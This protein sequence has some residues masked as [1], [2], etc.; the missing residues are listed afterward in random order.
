MRPRHRLVTLAL[1][2]ARG[3]AAGAPGPRGN[4]PTVTRRTGVML[5]AR[6]GINLRRLP[7]GTVVLLLV[8][9]FAAPAQAWSARTTQM[10]VASNGT[11]ADLG[12]C[13]PPSDP[14]EPSPVCAEPDLSA[15]SADGRFV[16]FQ[17]SA[18]NLVPHD[19]NNR[20]DVFVHDRVNGA[21]TRVSVSSARRQANGDS[22]GPDISGDGRF[23]SFV[24]DASNLVARDT[25]GCTDPATGTFCADVFVHDLRSGMTT[26]INVSSTGAQSEPDPG[27]VTASIAGNGRYVAFTA[28]ASN[29]VPG[30]ANGGPDVFV[31][32]RVAGT[33]RVVSVG[34]DSLPADAS[35]GG[36]RPDAS[37]DGRFVVFAT[38]SPLVG[39]DSNGLF[40]I[41]LRDRRQG[42]T[43]RVSLRPD[44]Q[45]FL[46]D[47]FR[48]HLSPDGRFVVF[49]MGFPGTAFVFDRVAGRTSLVADGAFAQA[50]S[51]HGR[52]VAF[53]SDAA[54]LV[55]G[56][57][58]GATDVFVRDQAVGTVR[59]VSVA[60]DGAQADD[61]SF[62]ADISADGRFVSFV[63]EATNLVP[64]D[65]NGTADV[66]AHGPLLDS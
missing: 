6:A 5:R 59:R 66:F 23:V 11:Q 53:T 29:L 65:T 28:S 2:G 12:V 43:T 45:Q 39:E 44:G 48:P 42:T 21:T 33:T 8:A 26:R 36:G 50:I 61:R 57:T 55:P 47:S 30:D 49:T 19:T 63:S 52:F 1:A 16:A 7:P 40:D 13:P 34:P 41:Y 9:L 18:S 4:E 3:G 60:S 35:G 10:D 27:Y 24:S 32:D 58:N 22:W 20:S 31:R 25:N 15:M 37:A 14:F 51:A 46:D 38:G 64:H 56:D 62:D 54:E 17:S